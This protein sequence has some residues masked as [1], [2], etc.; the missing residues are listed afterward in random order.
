MISCEI[1]SE[2]TFPNVSDKFYN[3][4]DVQ[5]LP[6]G[7]IILIDNGADRPAAQGGE[8]SRTAEYV[9][10]HDAKTVELVWEFVPHFPDG[11]NVVCFHGGSITFLDN[12]PN[13]KVRF[14]S[15]PCDEPDNGKTVCSITA[16]EI[17]ENGNQLAFVEFQN[18]VASGEK[19]IGSYRV[20]PWS[21]IDGEQT[22][23]QNY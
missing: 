6:N 19:F 20:E 23:Y 12:D 18:I 10:D 14:A 11:A 9:I 7:N 5:Q 17:D 22:L 15:F 21:S 3:Q 2:Y 16:F 13:A 1:D 8:Y 4:H